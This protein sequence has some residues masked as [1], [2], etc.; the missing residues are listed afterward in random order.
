MFSLIAD[1]IL[2]AIALSYLFVFLDGKTGCSFF[3]DS[4]TKATEYVR[5][6]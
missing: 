4:I 3:V 2:S 5:I 1:I 6:P